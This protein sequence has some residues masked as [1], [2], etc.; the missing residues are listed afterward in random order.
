MTVKKQNVQKRKHLKWLKNLFL[1]LR[2]KRL[3]R[4]RYSTKRGKK[5]LKKKPIS[6]GIK[7]VSPIKAKENPIITPRPENYWEAWQTFNPGVI[8]LNNRVHFLY[9]AVG[10][11]GISRFGYASSSDGFIIDERLPYPVYEHKLIHR[12]FS[13]YSYFSGGGWGGA[14]DPRI[15]QIKGEN[16]LYITYTTCDKGLRI[17]L[18]SINIDD[19]LNKNWNWKKPVLISPPYQLNKNWVLF[20]EKI[21]GKYAILQ[22]IVPQIEITYIESLEYFDGTNFIASSRDFGPIKNCDSKNYWDKWVRGAGPVPLKT[23]YGWLLFYHGMD[24]DWSKYKVGAMLLDLDDPT[25]ILVRSPEPILEPNQTYENNG[26]KAGIVYASGAI[27]KDGNIL[28]YYGA[29]DSYVCVAYANFEEFIE[30]LNKSIKPKLQQK[31]LRKK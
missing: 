1:L 10:I 2:G 15:V 20:P 29:A 14:E 8:L 24:N 12:E 31:I 22:S 4:K 9:R 30:T 7:I 18:S 5:E 16:T 13:I 21:K 6:I 19:F 25:K 3:K 28:I 27:V 17:A 26:F 11:D 23:K